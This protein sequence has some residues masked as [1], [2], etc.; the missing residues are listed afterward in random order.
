MIN[1]PDRI[2]NDE[3]MVALRELA[4]ARQFLDAWQ[5]AERATAI[6]DRARLAPLDL[7]E[8]VASYGLA[9]A[10]LAREVGR[11]APRVAAIYLSEYDHPPLKRLQLINGERRPV[12][13]YLELDR[14]IFDR[15]W[16]EL[17]GNPFAELTAV[18]S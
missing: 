2:S 18:A 16:N 5:V 9:D 1:H 4:H 14:Y 6:L 7:V 13:A 3:A 12:H 8:Y 11:L 15:A 17:H 10:A